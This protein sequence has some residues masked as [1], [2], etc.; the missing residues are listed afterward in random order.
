[1]SNVELV[2]VLVYERVTI[3]LYLSRAIVNR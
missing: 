1:M 2:R 3:F